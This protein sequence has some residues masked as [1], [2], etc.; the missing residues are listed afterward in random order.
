MDTVYKPAPPGLL[1]LDDAA[2]DGGD[3]R[4]PVLIATA[5]PLPQASGRMSLMRAD[6]S[7]AIS[8]PSASRKS[9]S[10]FGA[11]ADHV[12]A[13]RKTGQVVIA[14]YSE[15]ARERLQGL[16]ED[17]GLI[18]AAPIADFRDVPEGKGG[19]YL[20]VWAL[21]HGFEGKGGLT[22]IS[23]QDVLGDRLI[24]RAPKKRRAENFLTETQSLDPRRSGRACRSR[25]R[26][27]SW[28]WRWS[29]RL[30]RRMNVS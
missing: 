20:A 24:R 30:A 5:L 27:L 13:K 14:S 21:E 17:Q 18:G 9:V 19:V 8:R 25:R 11:L 23:E 3:G 4:A 7:G 12:E 6:G 28:G 2:W 15:G 10:L 26:A 1:Y 16:M 29:P 22:V